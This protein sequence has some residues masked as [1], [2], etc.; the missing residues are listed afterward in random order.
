MAKKAAKKTTAKKTA[1]SSAKAGGKGGGKAQPAA[2]Q[3]SSEAENSIDSAAFKKAVS[4]LEALDEQL[5]SEKGKYMERALRI[6]Q[7]KAVV[8]DAAKEKGI[9]RKELRAVVKARALERKADA[10]FE[11]LEADEQ[12]TFTAMRNILG[13]WSDDTPLGKFANDQ[14]AAAGKKSQKEKDDLLSKIGRGDEKEPPADAATDPEKP[15]TLN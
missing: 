8:T 1:K 3:A 6:S 13:D 5:L 2:K 11:D 9:P 12:D 15:P 4:E 14:K 7:Q 10:I